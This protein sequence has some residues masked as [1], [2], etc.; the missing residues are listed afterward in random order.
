ME[1]N[2][3]V[4]ASETCEKCHWPQIGGAVRLR[5]LPNY[6][7]D[8]SNTASHTVLSMVVGGSSSSGI[9]G[10]HFG[11]GVRVRYAA[12]DAK[13]QT[14]PWVEYRDEKT[15]TV[16]AY[17]IAGTTAGEV[18]KLATHEMQCVDCHNRP[19]HAFEFPERAVNR[20]IASG[21]IA[22]L[23]PFVKKKSMELLQASY[24]DQEIAERRIVEG[25]NGYYRQ[26]HPEKFAQHA[27]EVDRAA[28]A[29]S[30]IYARNVFPDLKVTWGTYPNNLGHTD[31]PGCFRCHDDGHTSADKKVITQDCASCHEMLAVEEGSPEILKT[32]NLGERIGQL[33]RR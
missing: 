9:H 30:A 19:A 17:A 13:R 14:I 24:P 2:R 29:V 25:L 3:L 18:A 5:V 7:D 32:L 12:T 26:S 16:R 27:R 23:L 15:S 11:P 33:Q 6:K 8:E 1:S 22:T 20:A 10:S 31:S 4:P 21:E 28:K